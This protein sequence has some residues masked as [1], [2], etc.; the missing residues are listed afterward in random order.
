MQGRSRGRPPSGDDDTDHRT[1]L[2]RHAEYWLPDRFDHLD[3]P[4]HDG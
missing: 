4:N 2:D 3:G 1:H